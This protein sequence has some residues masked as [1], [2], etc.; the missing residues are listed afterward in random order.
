MKVKR[1]ENY[2]RPTYRPTDRPTDGQ[3]DGLIGYSL[4]LWLFRALIQWSLPVDEDVDVVGVVQWLGLAPDDCK[5]CRDVRCP[6]Q[7]K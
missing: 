6:E 3:T 7:I 2:D 1:L 5:R 4:T